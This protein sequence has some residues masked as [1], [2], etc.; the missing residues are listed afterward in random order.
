MDKN[1]IPTKEESIKIF[2]KFVLFSNVEEHCVT[3]TSVATYLANKIYKKR[4]PDLNL[5]LIFAAALFHD[6]GKGLT[7]KTLEPDKYGF[8]PL[9]EEQERNWRLQVSFYEPLKNLFA[10]LETIRPGL[11]KKVHETDLA[12]IIVGSLYPDFI[13]HIHRIGGANNQI[14]FESGL[15]MKIVHY[16]DWIVHQFNL[17][18]FEKRLDYIF[19]RY[20]SE[21]SED[22][23]QLRKKKE[24]ALEQ[25]LFDG[26]DITPNNLSLDEINKLKPEL[27]NGEFDYFQTQRVSAID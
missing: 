18:P 24:F 16:A 9:T 27:F 11:N 1:T 22:Q 10:E 6:L 3:V 14:Y 13:P 2:K 5:D 4:A 21:Q 20:C 26:L 19:S 8:R 7:I 12:S 23:C 15:E 25:E 17:I